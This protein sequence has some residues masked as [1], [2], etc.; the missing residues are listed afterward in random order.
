GAQ[1]ARNKAARIDHDRAV[2]EVAALELELRTHLQQLRDRYTAQ[3]GRVEA[4]ELGGAQEAAQL[5]K[6]SEDAFVSG[7]IDRLEWSLLN[8]Q[9]INLT[10]EHLD[11]LL[12]LGRISIELDRYNEQ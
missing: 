4:L 9:A 2:N 6:A 5:R 12:A 8:G 1:D 7:Q 3:L 10:L 11:A